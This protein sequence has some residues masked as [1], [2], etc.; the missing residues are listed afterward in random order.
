MKAQ[1]DE[2]DIPARVMVELQAISPE[3]YR[4]LKSVEL[5]RVTEN[6]AFSEPVQIYSN[7]QDGWGIFG[8][9]SSERVYIP[10]DWTSINLG[11]PLTCERQQVVNWNR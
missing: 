6:D 10:Y 9:L 7:V 3:Y 8:S 2:P 11:Q 1:A 4:Y 5:Y